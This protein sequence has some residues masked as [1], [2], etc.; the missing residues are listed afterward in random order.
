MRGVGEG[1]SSS[2]NWSGSGSCGSAYK[3]TVPHVLIG[4]VLKGLGKGGT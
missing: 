1:L 3:A 4:G 2:N